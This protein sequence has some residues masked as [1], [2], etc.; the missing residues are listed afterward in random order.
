MRTPEE[1]IESIIRGLLKQ[2]SLFI[3]LHD[4]TNPAVDVLKKISKS[5]LFKAALTSGKVATTLAGATAVNDAIDKIGEM[6][7]G[8]NAEEEFN[9]AEFRE[10]V[11]NSID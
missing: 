4:H 9:P 3:E 10:A 5:R 2:V 7:N 8:E 1:S 11:A 6:F